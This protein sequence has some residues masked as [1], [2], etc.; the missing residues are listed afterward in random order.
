MQTQVQRLMS[1]SYLPDGPWPWWSGEG[2]IIGLNF[3]LCVKIELELAL[4]QRTAK[5]PRFQEQAGSSSAC[6][7]VVLQVWRQARRH[8]GSPCSILGE[9]ERSSAELKIAR[10]LDL[11][12]IHFTVH[13]PTAWSAEPR[14]VTW[15]SWLLP[16]IECV[17]AAAAAHARVLSAPASNK[18]AEA[19]I[20]QSFFRAAS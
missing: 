6:T 17:V 8:P 18:S 1:K 12:T 19:G 7:V 14:P 15:S 4:T 13:H 3:F 11:F 2:L 10:L 20:V 16:P 5:Y 9:Q